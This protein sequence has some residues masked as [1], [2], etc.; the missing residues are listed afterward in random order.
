MHSEL[1]SYEG[2]VCQLLI[3]YDLLFFIF[4]L[5]PQFGEVQLTDLLGDCQSGH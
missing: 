2:A 1:A 3:V 5:Y 4:L